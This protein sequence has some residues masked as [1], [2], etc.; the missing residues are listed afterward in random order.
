MSCIKFGTVANCEGHSM[1]TRRCQRLGIQGIPCGCTSGCSS[2][3]FSWS[4]SNRCLN[5]STLASTRLCNNHIIIY[6]LHAVALQ[7]EDGEIPMKTW[8]TL[9]STVQSGG[10]KDS[11][12]DG[13]LSGSKCDTLTPKS[14][15]LRRGA[16]ARCLAGHK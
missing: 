8:G 6:A 1:L 11:G 13:S 10:S 16:I 5:R 3:G 15:D 7:Q 14:R 12:V 4:H 9:L 2:Q